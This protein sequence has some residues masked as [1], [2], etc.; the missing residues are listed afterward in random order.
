[1]DFIYDGKALTDLKAGNFKINSFV[2]NVEGLGMEL[3]EATTLQNIAR[4]QA[5]AEAKEEKV[6]VGAQPPKVPAQIS[7]AIKQVLPQN[8]D[9]NLYRFDFG[10]IPRS[11]RATV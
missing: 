8:K 3:G 11:G 9:R 2:R 10:T 6:E 4:A 1:M 7:N 5:G